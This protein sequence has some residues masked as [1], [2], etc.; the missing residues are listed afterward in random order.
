MSNVTS[1]KAG[2]TSGTAMSR[3]Q[4]PVLKHTVDIAAAVTAGLTTGEYIEVCTIPAETYLKIWDVKNATALSLGS[5]PEIEL[6]DADDDDLYVAAAT[7]ETVDTH[8]ALTGATAIGATTRTE[9][10]YSSA[11]SLRLKVTGGTIASGKVQI[12]YSL[13]PCGTNLPA[14]TDD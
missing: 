5:S 4:V 12:T 2:G 9:K 8:H 1:L 14:D 13:I 7:T 6:G 10:F 3:F 11:G